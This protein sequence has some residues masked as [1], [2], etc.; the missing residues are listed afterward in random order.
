MILLYDLVQKS[1][2]L[3]QMLRDLAPYYD[4]L[5]RPPL[6][7]ILRSADGTYITMLQS[8]RSTQIASLYYYL[9]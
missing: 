9:V 2:C 1:D 6:G 3:I 8:L 4:C 7:F 5:I